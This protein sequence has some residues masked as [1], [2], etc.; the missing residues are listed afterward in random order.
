[1]NQN[2]N[3]MVAPSS[4]RAEVK[5]TA[6][7]KGSSRQ[8]QQGQPPQGRTRL[9]R[10]RSAAGYKDANGVPSA[11]STTMTA[12]STTVQDYSSNSGGDKKVISAGQ[13]AAI[14]RI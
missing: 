12:N 9:H 6:N 7:Q 8:S 13:Q 5:P 2:S 11:Q 10:V 1:M 4:S 14:K 3:F